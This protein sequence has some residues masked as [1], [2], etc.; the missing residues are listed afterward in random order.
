MG[1]GDDWTGR[2]QEVRESTITFWRAGDYGRQERRITYM[3][4]V[5]VLANT[6][7]AKG[8]G[9]LFLARPSAGQYTLICIG[10]EGLLRYSQCRQGK[11]RDK[12]RIKDYQTAKLLWCEETIA[13]HIRRRI[14]L[15]TKGC[16]FPVDSPSSIALFLYTFQ[17][18]SSLLL[19]SLRGAVPSLRC[20]LLSIASSSTPIQVCARL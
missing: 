17:A 3:S 9:E 13:V 15:H 4:T 12:T 11:D 14:S 19:Y 5:T 8:A 18:S 1:N 10:N 20:L 2:N 16:W 6:R 7:M